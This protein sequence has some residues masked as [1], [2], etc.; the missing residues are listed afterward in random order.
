MKLIFAQG[1]PEQ[2]YSATRHNIGFLTLDSLA[3]KFDAKWFNKSK[4]NATIAEAKISG[5]KVLLVKPTTYYNE[6]GLSVRKLV[7]FYKLNPASDLL[8][9]HDDLAL[10]F[11]TVRV[12]KQ[13]SDGGNNGIKSINAC[14]G[15]DYIRIRI[16][17][18]NDLRDKMDDSNF[19][20]S[21]FH[22]KELESLKE[23]IIPHVLNLVEQF[24]DGK[25]E[26]TSYKI[27]E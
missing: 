26:T 16:G 22:G 12:R 2:K 1:N 20:L 21:K 8:V 13:G 14:I 9:I 17:T 15:Q 11:S 23:N 25:I 5:E 24:C 6:T 18:Y 3:E 10:P 7:D 4:F 27:L 19:V